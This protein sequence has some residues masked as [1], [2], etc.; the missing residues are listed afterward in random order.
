MNKYTTIADIE[1]NAPI[2]VAYVGATSWDGHDK[3]IDCDLWRVTLT[4]PKSAGFWSTD[5]RTGFGLRKK[6]MPCKPS[7]AD[8]MHCLILD[9]SAADENFTDWCSNC[10][11][12]DGSIKALNAYQ[13]C[14]ETAHALRKYIGREDLAAIAELLK[15]Y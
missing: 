10:G 9:A 11:Y 2:T 7:K 6:G 5:Y 8:I 12:S 4:G 14:I 15:D 1:I 13:A 3:P